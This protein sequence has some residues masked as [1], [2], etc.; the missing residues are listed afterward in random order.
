MDGAGVL[1]VR[2]TLT[3]AGYSL[4]F[5]ITQLQNFI[6]AYYEF[7]PGCNYII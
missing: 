2:Q 5:H 4:L 6:L 7:Q 1:V 3:V